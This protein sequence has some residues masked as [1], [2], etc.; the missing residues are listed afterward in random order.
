MKFTNESNLDES[1]LI[2]EASKADL[3]AFNHLVL[4]YQNSIFNQAYFLLGDPH[5]AEDVTQ[6][7]FIKAFR[8]I[9]EFRGGSFR[10]W[11][12][13][14][15]INT[16]YDRMRWSKR[17]PTL[18]LIPEDGYGEEI[19]TPSWLSDPNRS[20]QAIVEQKDLSRILSSMLNELPEIY[21]N[22]IILVDVHELDYSEAAEVLG[23]PIGTLKS[24]LARARFQMKKRLQNNIDF[25]RNFGP[26]NSRSIVRTHRQGVVG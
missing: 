8:N 7:S 11:L 13:K 14:I 4:K 24:R 6:E 10:A 23:I 2:L 26:T 25:T 22:P 17:H 12:L 9:G 16:C 19:D 3:E 15:V 21:R 18:P 1:F 20:I 5:S